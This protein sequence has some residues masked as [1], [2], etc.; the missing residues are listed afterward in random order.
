MIM[1]AIINGNRVECVYVEPQDGTIEI[2]MPDN[3]REHEIT[4]DNGIV[5]GEKIDNEYKPLI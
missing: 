4:Y 2:D 1:Y 3:W 5:L